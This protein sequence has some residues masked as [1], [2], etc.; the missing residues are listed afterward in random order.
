MM[1]DKEIHKTALVACSRLVDF[2]GAEITSLE[3]AEALSNLGFKVLL[4]ALEVGKE[5]ADEMDILRLEYVDLSVTGIKDRNFD[6][7]WVSHSVAAYH[8]M[9][10]EG[11]RAKIGIF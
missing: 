2:A 1:L 9:V 4:A 5:V 6:L 8:L 11:V 3:I 7:V 10:N